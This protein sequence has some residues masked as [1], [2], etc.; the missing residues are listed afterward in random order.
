MLYNTGAAPQIRSWCNTTCWLLPHPS[1]ALN[2]WEGGKK[3]GEI[4]TVVEGRRKSCDPCLL[5][6]QCEVST[7]LNST[8]ASHELPVA[9]SLGCRCAIP[10]KHQQSVTQSLLGKSGWAPWE[11]TK[12]TYCQL[13]EEHWYE[14]LHLKPVHRH[15]S[16]I[17]HLSFR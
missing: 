12:G 14:A 6:L 3:K 2:K 9:L 16:C 5:L 15:I 17:N 7:S 1:A 10:A 11:H 13:P 8:F 4:Q